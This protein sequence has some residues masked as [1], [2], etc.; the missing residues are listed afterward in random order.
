MNS[1]TTIND[2]ELPS[3][4]SVVSCKV[5]GYLINMDTKRD[6]HVVKCEKCNEAT[7]SIVPCDCVLIIL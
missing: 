5:C 4:N 1:S 7:V 2:E 3:V 6:Q